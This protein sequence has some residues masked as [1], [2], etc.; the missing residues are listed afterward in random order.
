MR[1][2]YFLC[3][4]LVTLILGGCITPPAFLSRS[5]DQLTVREQRLKCQKKC[6]D[7][8]KV[9]VVSRQDYA[10]LQQRVEKLQGDNG[11]LYRKVEEQNQIIARQKKVVSLQ[12]TVI[13]LFDDSNHST[14][15]NIAQQ[16]AAQHSTQHQVQEHRKWTFTN[17]SLFEEGTTVLTPAGREK[18]KKVGAALGQEGTAFIRVAGHA[19]DRPLKKTAQYANNWELSTLRAAAVVQLLQTVCGLPPE[20]LS[21]TGYGYY[22]PLVSNEN[23]AGRQRNSRIEI[24][25]AEPES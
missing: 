16:I 22:H 21:A 2:T 25:V 11:F 17:I 6:S 12:E 13:R 23:A 14:Q 5:N 18:L 24:S 15:K 9:I 10:E 19:D 3:C 8:P 4:G 20:R 7:F 1:K